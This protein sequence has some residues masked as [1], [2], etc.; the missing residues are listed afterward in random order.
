MDST[1]LSGY[2]WTIFHFINYKMFSRMTFYTQSSNLNGVFN[3]GNKAAS[4]MCAFHIV[5]NVVSGLLG[6]R[7]A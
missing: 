4:V 6:R 1:K 3:D 7:T 2:K 5:H